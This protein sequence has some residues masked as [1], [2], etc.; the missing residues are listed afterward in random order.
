MRSGTGP[1]R[2]NRA[3]ILSPV[4]SAE[5]VAA[6]GVTEKVPSVLKVASL[7]SKRDSSYSADFPGAV[8]KLCTV[9]SISETVVLKPPL[10]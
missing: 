9:K 5:D 4:S 10:G 3:W 8:L 7:S 2:A 6:S 1:G